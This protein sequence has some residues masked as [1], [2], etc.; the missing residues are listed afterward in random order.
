MDIFPLFHVSL[1][2]HVLVGQGTIL[3]LLAMTQNAICVNLGNA[4]DPSTM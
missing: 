2:H 4:D 1:Q 3:D